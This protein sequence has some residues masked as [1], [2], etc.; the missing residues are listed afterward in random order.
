MYYLLLQLQTDFNILL[1]W[2]NISELLVSIIGVPID[3]V[4]ALQ[5]GWKLGYNV[6]VVTGWILTFLGKIGSLNPISNIQL[7]FL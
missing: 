7:Y 3:F 4:A 5:F 1:I 2:L 6:C